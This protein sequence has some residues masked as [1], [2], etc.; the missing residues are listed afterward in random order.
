MKKLLLLCICTL[1]G[2]GAAFATEVDQNELIPT[3]DKPVEFINYN[4]RHAK[5]DSLRAIAAIGQSLASAIRTGQAGA[6]NRYALIHAVDSTVKTGLDADILIIGRNAQVDHI[7]NL[8]V[9]IAAYLQ[10]AYGY[11]QKD[12]ETIAYFITIYNAVYRKDLASFTNRYKPAVLKHLTADRIGLALHYSEWPGATQIVIPLSDEKYQGTLSSV[13]TSFTSDKKILDKMREESDKD[14][15]TRKDLID[16]KERESEEAKKRADSSQK[17]ALQKQQESDALQKEAQQSKAAAE[18]LKNEASQAQAEADAAKKHAEQVREE[19]EQAR[20]RAQAN[21]NDKE[22]AKAAEEKQRELEQAEQIAAEKQKEATD[23]ALAAQ[24]ERENAAQK[25]AAADAKQKE[26]DLAKQQA[27]SEEAFAAQ[28]REEAQGDRKDVAVDTRKII[29]NIE[30]E[31]KA[32]IDTSFASIFPGIMFK[33]IDAEKMLSEVVLVDLKTGNIVKNSSINTIYSRSVIETDKAF[34]V[35]SKTK[36]SPSGVAL[37]A[38]DSRTLEV[39]KQGTTAMAEQSTL[40]QSGNSFYAVINQN[41]KYFLGRFDTE[42]ALQAT[43]KIAVL[44][45]TSLITTTKGILV[46]DTA[47]TIKLLNA[48]NL[49]EQK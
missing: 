26:A 34:I 21:P 10:S 49:T 1:C 5:I 25:Q 45:Y 42:L 39:T 17:E 30:P 40:A 4:G 7:T 47:N 6:M 29:E 13:Y 35:L 16:L 19:A 22:A 36:D 18:R 24:L 20:K 27:A 33:I 2:F 23:K 44:P 48:D 37:V 11:S 9:I 28:K 41:G 32:Q 43:S 12:A 8:R 3:E 15:G 46:Q 14:I 31:K 38:L